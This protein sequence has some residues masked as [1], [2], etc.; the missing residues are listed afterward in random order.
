MPTNSTASP[1]SNRGEGGAPSSYRVPFLLKYRSFFSIGEIEGNVILQLAFGALLILCFL[2]FFRG[3]ETSTAITVES[4]ANNSYVCWPYF[5]TCGQYYFLHALPYGYSQTILYAILLGVMFL[6]AWAMYAKKWVYAH[7][8]LA[9][10]WIWKVLVVFVLSKLLANNFDYYDIILL[11]I[12]LMLPRKLF[13]L[14]LTFV[15]FYFLGATLKFDDGWILGTYFTSL[16]I[17]LPIFGNALAPILTNLVTCVEVVGCWF[18]LSDRRLLQRLAFCFFFA[19]HL[20]S[21]II[22]N[23]R[24]PVAALL[25]LVILFGINEENPP[26]PLDRR[27]VFGWLLL[28]FLFCLQLTPFVM[29]ANPELTGE[30][31]QYRFFMFEA[32]HQCRSEITVYEKNGSAQSSETDSIN[33]RDRC[34]PYNTWFG[35]KQRCERDP[36]IARIGWTFDHSLDGGPFYR[37]IDVPDACALTYHAFSQ[38]AWIKTPPLAPV[39]GYPVKNI[40]F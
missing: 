16:K 24:F 25:M 4:Y 8:G 20:Y 28:A 9:A 19:F 22:I 36:T 29:H 37:I 2:T 6:T 12:L 14:R 38:N 5:Q 35:L 17:G 30:G 13:F 10:L 15:S 27:S 26:V 11:F 21:S 40:L 3:W 32:N 33:S 18:L 39:V 1:G 34:D 31:N 7:M 23:Y